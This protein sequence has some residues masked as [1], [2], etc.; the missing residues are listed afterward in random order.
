MVVAARRTWSGWDTPD[1]AVG[2]DLVVVQPPDR[3]RTL[4]LAQGLKPLLV[5][6][7]VPELAVET[8]DV[9]VFALAD[10]ARSGCA[11]CRE[12]VPRPRRPCW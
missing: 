5:Q 6:A 2:P 9:A 3:R 10:L 11:G 12:I 1:A 8:L 7:L 4:G